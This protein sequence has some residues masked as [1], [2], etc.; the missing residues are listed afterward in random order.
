V[1]RRSL[2]DGHPRDLAD[3]AFREP[4]VAVL[5]DVDVADRPSAARDRPG[6]EVLRLR[7][8]S[9]LSMRRIVAPVALFLIALPLAVS[10][11]E[12]GPYPNVTGGFGEQSCHLCPLP[13]PSNA[14]NELDSDEALAE[15]GSAPSS[16]DLER[17]W[18]RCFQGQTSAP[19]SSAG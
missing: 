10:A 5:V 15:W 18:L 3:A 6:Q 16:R 7:Y 2:L 8:E 4:Q 1:R 14:P 12:E 19:G 17:F 13:N 9:T 11:F